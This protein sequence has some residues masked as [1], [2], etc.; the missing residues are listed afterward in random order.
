MSKVVWIASY[1][2]S[3]NTWIRFLVSNLV[4]GPIDSAATLN[5]L[6]P[7]IHEL[8]PADL[9]A[10]SNAVLMKTHFPYSPA[11]PLAMH[12]AGAIYVLRDPADVML[13]NYYYRQRSGAASL[14]D[15]SDF[16]RYLDA[17]IVARGD[18]R[19]LQLGMGS[20]DG[21]VRSWLSA[22]HEFPVLKIRYEDLL[23]DGMKVAALLSR[24][25]GLRAEAQ[26]LA[27]AVQAT[28]FDSMRRIEEADISA[29]RVGIFYRPYLQVPIDAGL[30][31]M[32]SGRS[33]DATRKMSP[34]QWQRF[35]AAFG[36]IREEFGYG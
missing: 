11:L 20:W 1:P 23:S 16:D 31:F 13:S 9:Q 34:C 21:N 22:P 3:G 36:S 32:R 17:F 2:K 15:E 18:P 12:T 33:G 24:S 7:D 25:L 8:R 28:S 19:W 10:P 30:R 26:R 35:N 4:Y 29:Q 6:V 27:A 5:R 14:D